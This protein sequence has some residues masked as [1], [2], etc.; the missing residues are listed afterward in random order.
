MRFGRF[1]STSNLWRRR[2]TCTSTVC[3]KEYRSRNSRFGW[4]VEAG[5]GIPHYWTVGRWRAEFEAHRQ[6]DCGIGPPSIED[7]RSEI[8]TFVREAGE[9]SSLHIKRCLICAGSLRS[10][11]KANPV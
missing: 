10:Q 3:V 7:V 6:D 1:G 8:Q 2:A 4:W 9:K 11:A 5:G